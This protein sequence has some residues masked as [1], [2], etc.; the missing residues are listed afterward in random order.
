MTKGNSDFS[1]SVSLLQF[2]SSLHFNQNYFCICLQAS[3]F[4]CVLKSSSLSNF[5]GDWHFV[6]LHKVGYMLF[7][8]MYIKV[9]YSVSQQ[10]ASVSH[11]S[12]CVWT[13]KLKLSLLEGKRFVSSTSTAVFSTN[14]SLVSSL[15]R[16][17]V[18]SHVSRN[19]ME[20]NIICTKPTSGRLIAS[21]V[22]RTLT[23]VLTRSLA[24]CLHTKKK[25]MSVL[26]LLI[27]KLH[28][29]AGSTLKDFIYLNLI[30]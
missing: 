23:N 20:V 8:L 26:A 27:C 1:T 3:P 28:G 22:G 25:K 5:T 13:V 19:T 17:I 7:F 6:P 30:K 9:F 21:W 15:Q 10:S 12:I 16:C 2:D 24:A 14:V 18:L 29:L 4:A 11:V